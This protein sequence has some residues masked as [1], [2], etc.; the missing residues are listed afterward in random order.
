M[1]IGS[2]NNGRGN[3]VVVLLTAATAGALAGCGAAAPQAAKPSPVPATSAP[4]STA[5]P[6]P[7]RPTAPLSVAP[8]WTVS[9][10]DSVDLTGSTL[11]T[12]LVVA[13]TGSAVDTTAVADAGGAFLIHVVGLVMGDNKFRVR[14]NGTPA[15]GQ[16]DTAN[17]V[18]SRTQSEG[19]YKNIASDIP[20]PQLV[21]DPA[22][23]AGRVVTSLAHVFQYDTATTTG[24]LI[25]SVTDGGYGYWTDNAWVDIDPKIAQS[26]CKGTI[27]RFWGDVVGPYTYKTTMNGSITIPEI[28][29]R[30][31][32]VVSKPC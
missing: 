25:L 19:A 17:V 14:V 22:A 27:L 30:Y 11:P 4:A 3:W 29:I 1:V 16:S 12:G 13:S 31:L 7:S 23:L 2:R 28:K 5:T 8:A 32:T 21:K 18:V 15:Y 26:V 6:T 10:V 24:N 20:Y 9:D